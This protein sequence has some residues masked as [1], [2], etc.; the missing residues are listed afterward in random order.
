MADGTPAPPPRRA[1]AAQ[2]SGKWSSTRWSLL[3]TAV[4]ASARCGLTP[5][6]AG[7]GSSRLDRKWRLKLAVGVT[8]ARRRGSPEPG[9]PSPGSV[10]VPALPEQ[11]SQCA[12][13]PGGREAQVSPW[14]PPALRSRDVTLVA[15][16]ELASAGASWRRGGPRR[17]RPQPPPVPGGAALI[18]RR[19]L[20]FCSG[21]GGR[22]RARPRPRPPSSF[23]ALQQGNQPQRARELRIPGH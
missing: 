11:G 5:A 22:T 4:R 14:Q 1:R 15:A 9:R 12:D 17:G 7:A 10:L 19:A 18:P 2:A 21:L 3:G 23:S 20:F 16:P 13:R 8:R 6:R